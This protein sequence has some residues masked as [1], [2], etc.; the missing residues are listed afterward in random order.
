MKDTLDQAEAGLEK[1]WSIFHGKGERKPA[2]VLS[3]QTSLLKILVQAES[4]YR[5][6]SQER[7]RLIR[8]KHRLNVS[9]FK[10]RQA[11]LEHYG[12]S[13]RIVL[14]IG[15]TLGDGFAWMFYR[16]EDQLIDEHLNHQR[17]HLLPPGVGGRGER[18]F[19]QNFQNANGT[20]AIYH[21]LTTFLR[22]GD[23]SFY[24]PVK[25]R[26][27]A[28]GE[29]K[30]TA[31]DDGLHELQM[32]II[33]Q[34]D[35]TL[36]DLANA[37]KA[38]PPRRKRQELPQQMKAR[39]ERQV[40]QIIAAVKNTETR[41][42]DDHFTSPKQIN[43]A[44]LQAVLDQPMDGKPRVE[45]AGAG[46]ML[47]AVDIPT[48]ISDR[49]LGDKSS[50]FMKQFEGVEREIAK[51]AIPDAPDN[52]LIIGF[53]GYSDD[54]QPYMLPGTT[55]LFWWPLDEAQKHN[56]I[57]GRTVVVSC[58]NPAHF[59]AMLRRRGYTLT[60]DHR[61]RIESAKKTMPDGKILQLENFS[62]F[63]NLSSGYLMDEDVIENIVEVMELKAAE[64][65]KDGPLRIQ[66]RPK[67]MFDRG[68]D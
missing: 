27:S 8:I 45:R 59:L 32:H 53:I 36:M 7:N 51:I 5:E 21:G 49:E 18:L 11:Q 64:K 50:D 33:A 46:L 16:N 6:I 26:I 63:Q 65:A 55:P 35:S 61:G 23:F 39:L 25:K 56:L 34:F 44:K 31:H 40:S 30:T 43:M 12:K 22:I 60:A 9:W 57:F 29:L 41:D 42:S 48:S 2:D 58:Y 10:R 4:V 54:H 28:I 62:Y 20:L 17:Q 3:L 66:I 52:A 14:G 1:C 13:I 47:I 24:D 67:I 19:L 38:G 15:R 68:E 37:A